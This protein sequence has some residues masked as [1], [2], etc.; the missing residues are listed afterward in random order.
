MRLLERDS[1]L[2]MSNYIPWELDI[3]QDDQ[4]PVDAAN[5]VVAYTRRDGHHARVGRGLV[6]FGHLVVVVAVVV[7]VLVA[8]GRELGGGD[9]EESQHGGEAG[10]EEVEG[11]G[12]EAYGVRSDEEAGVFERAM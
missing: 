5:G 9:V 7:A 10:E 1:S 3:L 12:G 6:V 2:S 11:D 8:E 4:R